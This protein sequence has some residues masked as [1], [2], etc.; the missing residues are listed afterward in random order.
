MKWLKNLTFV[1]ATIVTFSAMSY[2]LIKSPHFF[3]S[4]EHEEIS[5]EQKFI[6]VNKSYNFKP[7]FT[8]SKLEK[9]IDELAFYQDNEFEDFFNAWYDEKANDIQKIQQSTFKTINSK[10]L[11][12]YV[13]E[14]NINL[15]V[16]F[17]ELE[18]AERLNQ[19]KI[20]DCYENDLRGLYES[21]EGREFLD[22][23]IEYFIMVTTMAMSVSHDFTNNY[24]Q[25]LAAIYVPQFYDVLTR[26]E[27]SAQTEKEKEQAEGNLELLRNYLEGGAQGNLDL[28]IYVT[29]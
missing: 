14:N 4:K 5:Y 10:E 28:Q 7:Y 27:T 6:P 8:K 29:F 2:W 16:S 15:F 9:Q 25:N 20:P 19:E 3:P 24:S 18:E 22:L 13:G 1:T 17:E 23:Q 12:C 21:A 11:L 26:W